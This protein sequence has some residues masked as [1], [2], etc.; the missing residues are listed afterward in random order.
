MLG[1]LLDRV[2]AD[3]AARRDELERLRQDQ[4]RLAEERDRLR[5]DL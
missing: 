5:D 4:E 2:A 1:L 3:E